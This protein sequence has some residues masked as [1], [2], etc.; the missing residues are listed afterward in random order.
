MWSSLGEQLAEEPSL[1]LPSL[2]RLT[3]LRKL[4]WEMT[5]LGDAPGG[6]QP[7]GG[8]ASLHALTRLDLGAFEPRSTWPPAIAALT[9][10]R[11]LYL[12]TVHTPLSHDI[13][14]LADASLPFLSGL[15]GLEELAIFWNAAGPCRLP[16]SIAALTH[17]TALTGCIEHLQ[18]PDACT[19]LEA[20]PG[21]RQLTLKFTGLVALPPCIS[22]LTSLQELDLTFNYALRLSPADARTVLA[23]LPCLE[24]VRLSQPAKAALSADD[25]AALAAA[26]PRLT[27][28]AWH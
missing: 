20:L 2:H 5:P 19:C 25:W 11:R 28:E 27:V 26:R 3:V 9:G 8:L 14:P 13:P 15:T 17:P 23:G 12:G 1:H 18:G 24:T 21:L 16:S 7:S 22:A 10:L 6:G 4:C